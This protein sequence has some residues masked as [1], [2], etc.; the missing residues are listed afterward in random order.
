MTILQ[1]LA[2]GPWILFALSLSLGF[3]VGCEDTRPP[4][5]GSVEGS[6]VRLPA[7][8]AISDVE[9]FLLRTSNFTVANGPVFTDAVGNYRFENVAVGRYYVFAF[10]TSD[11]LFDMSEPTVEVMAD[12]TAIYDI[13]MVASRLWDGEG[14]KIEGRVLDS[15]T[16]FPI[17]GA[18]VT[19]NLANLDFNIAGLQTPWDEIT[20]ERGHYFLEEVPPVIFGSK[21]ATVPFQALLFITKEGY[22]PKALQGLTFPADADSVLEVTT[23]LTPAGPGMRLAGKVVSAGEPVVGPTGAQEKAPVL[24]KVSVTDS[25]GRFHFED[26]APGTYRI[27]AGIDLDDGWSTKSREYVR[28]VTL[29][30]ADSTGVVVQVFPAIRPISPLPGSTIADTTPLL[31]WEPVPGAATYHVQLGTG[32]LLN[33]VPATTEPRWQ[34]AGADSLPAGGPYPVRWLVDAEDAEGRFLGTTET[35]LSFEVLTP[36]PVD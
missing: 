26:L 36:E 5:R 29:E 14:R 27:Q 23:E 17:R 32:H 34:W 25:A 22:E 12:S 8:D 9:I 13:R 4:K 1:K 31:E 10:V 2:R 24:G 7:G 20:D 11:V 30:D 19:S 35:T 16:G 3:A 6:L 15:R 33:D 18:F 21:A 28:E